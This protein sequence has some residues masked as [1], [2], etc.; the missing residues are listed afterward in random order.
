MKR[1]LMGSSAYYGC[2]KIGHNLS[3]CPSV[4]NRGKKDR[5]KDKLPMEV[6][7]NKDLNKVVLLTSSV[8]YMLDKSWRRLLMLLR[9]SCRSLILMC[10]N[11]LIQVQIIHL[12]IPFL[13]LGLICAPNFIRALLVYTLVSELVWL[14][15]FIEIVQCWFCIK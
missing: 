13:P 9:V 5:P 2:N 1:C 3:N 14:K 4:T 8:L 15:E 6:K 7:D 10:M 11:F 12:L